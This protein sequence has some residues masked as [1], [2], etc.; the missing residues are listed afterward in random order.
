[1]PEISTLSFDAA[2]NGKTIDHTAL[3]IDGTGTSDAIHCSRVQNLTFTCRTVI[4][5]SE[6][7]ADVNN[8]CRNVTLSATLWVLS[9]SLGITIKGGSIGTTV[10]GRVRGPGFIDLGNWSD[11][12]HAKTRSTRLN[13]TR[14][15]YD[16]SAPIPI[17]VLHAD[18]PDISSGGPYV[19]LF[20][21][22]RMGAP[23]HAA[24][25]FCFM[26]LRRWGFFRT[27]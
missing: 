17:R 14:D 18:A 2:S 23:L 10:S 5:G 6:D 1:M 7:A 21:S 24:I 9:G 22:P 25:V 12:S 16:G 26:T 19:Y 20:P 8:E 11:Q 4:S 3:Y 27:P 13:L 15:A